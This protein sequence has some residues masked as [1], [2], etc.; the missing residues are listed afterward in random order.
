[1]SYV[2]EQG[3]AALIKVAEWLEA[4]APHTVLPHGLRV[5]TFDMTVPVGVDDECGTSCCIAGAV[6]Q[7]EGLGLEVRD[8]DG[9]LGWMGDIGAMDLA[10]AFLGMDLRSQLKM[11]EPWNHFYG[12]DESFNAAP[13]GAAVIR[14]FLATGE[15]DW[16]RFNPDGSLYEEP[17]EEE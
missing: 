3:R 2:S 4:G 6:C 17:T 1:M 5:D 8:A 16:D 7:F 10:G 11:F 12:D 14:H 13:R 15:V 9:S